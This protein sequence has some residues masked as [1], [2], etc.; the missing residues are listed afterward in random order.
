M[1]NSS[2]S[3]VIGSKKLISTL[4]PLTLA[5]LTNLNANLHCASLL[6][7]SSTNIFFCFS[8]HAA[9]MSLA[10]K[11]TL[12]P[13]I[14]YSLLFPLVPTTPAKTRPVVIPIEHAQAMAFKSLIKSIAV[15]VAL[16]GS[17]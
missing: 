9:C 7:T 5:F 2:S 6:V 8:P 3:A 12:S 10:A 4:F 13:K 17:S 16:T 14:E 11:L 1:F 15:R